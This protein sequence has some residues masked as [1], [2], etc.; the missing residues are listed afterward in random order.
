ML[1]LP[2]Q[3]HFFISKLHADRR[4]LNRPGAGLAA[5]ALCCVV[6]CSDG[7]DSEN[8][9][10]AAG[11]GAANASGGNAGRGGTASGNA[12]RGGA[13]SGAPGT[14]GTTPSGSGGGG[15]A[16]KAGSGGQA[17]LPGTGGSTGGSVAAGGS[18]AMA[19]AGAGGAPNGGTAGTG[20]NAGAGMGGAPQT[21]GCDAVTAVAEMKLGWNLGNSLDSIAPAQSDTTVETAW[22]NPV[23]T[24]ELM[25]AVAAAGFGAVRIPVTWIGRFGPAPDYTIRPTFLARVEQVVNYAL[26]QDLYVIINLHHDGAD[27][28]DGQWLSLVDESRQV[29]ATH[30][31]AVLV[32]FRKIWE[33]VADHFAGF[34]NRL[35]FEGMNE[36]KV[37]YDPPLPAYYDGINDLNQ[38]FVDTVRASGGNNGQ[39]C[40]VVPGYNTNIE[41]TIAGFEAPVDTSPG[42]LIL[43]DHYYDPWS[44]AGEAATQTWGASSPG[45]DSWG[46]EEWVVSQ[47]AKLKAKFIDHGLPMIWGEYGAVHQ[48]GYENYRRY[49]MEYVTKACHDAGIVPF[50]WDNGSKNSGAEA[51]G[52]F[53]RSNNM[54]LNAPLLEALKRAVTSTYQLSDVAKP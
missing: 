29:N 35:I 20:A 37:G 51:F 5:L 45:T 34:G 25:A 8:T 26:E 33:Q 15:S 44:F 16:G 28:V 41:Y 32:Q 4:W 24:P 10:G 21:G 19:G 30:S 53:D 23:I 12:G 18:S 50:V 1:R 36:V 38:A 17:G 2:R 40:L 9:G 49:Y 39:R 46:Q 11:S 22:G 14:G 43:S 13:A 42:K 7:D 6:S 27:L 52:L 54:P 31:A 47:I 3:N 48:T